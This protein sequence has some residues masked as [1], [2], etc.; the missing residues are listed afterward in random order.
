MP[1]TA[2][3]SR[4]P[5]GLRLYKA[6]KAAGLSQK[7]VE[8][9]LGIAQS[10]LS[11][12][13]RE[14]QS[15][16]SIAQLAALYKV[17]AHELATGEPAPVGRGVAQ[18]MSQARETMSLSKMTWGDLMGANLNQPFELDVIDDALAPEIFKGCVARLDPGRKPQPGQPVLV[19]DRNGQHYL[20]DY[21]QGSGDRWQAVARTRGFA[22][23]DSVDDGLQ[24]VAA[25]K[26]VDWP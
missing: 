24:L 2:T 7:D 13:E 9:A 5:F 20:R 17:D 25:V 10:T 8:A 18:D 1:E 4:T 3:R 14:G 16:G 23:L 12:M 6:R 11:E 26:G 15:S 21:Q 19:R 22:P